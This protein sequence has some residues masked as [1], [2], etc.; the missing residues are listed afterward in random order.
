MSSQYHIERHEV[1]VRLT[2]SEED[3]ADHAARD[4][5]RSVQGDAVHGVAVDDYEVPKSNH[6]WS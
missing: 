2:F 3:G 5:A 6:K 1:R 4:V